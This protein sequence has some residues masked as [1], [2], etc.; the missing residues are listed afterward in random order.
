MPL[1][2]SVSLL[3]TSMPRMFNNNLTV[4]RRPSAKLSLALQGYIPLTNFLLG[5][6]SG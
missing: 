2:F 1:F 3:V 5:H 6:R 4:L